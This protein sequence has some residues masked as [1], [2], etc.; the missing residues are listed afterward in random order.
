MLQSPTAEEVHAATALINEVFHDFCFDSPASR[1]NAFGLLLTAVLRSLIC[2]CVPAAMINGN[3]PGVG[4]G[5]LVD[6]ISLIVMGTEAPKGSAP[7]NDDEMRK[8][9]T[10]L[11]LAGT[12]FVVLDNLKKLLDHA[13]LDAFL[14]SSIWRDRR[15]HTNDTIELPNRSVMIL[16]G[17]NVKV[18]TDMARR[19]YLIQLRTRIARPWEKNSWLHSDL[20][21]WVRSE[22]GKLIGALLTICAGWNAAG[23][24]RST[25]VRMGSFEDW[26]SVIAGILEF[27]GIEGFLANRRDLQ[28]S[29][30]DAENE[31]EDFLT[32]IAEEMGVGKPFTMHELV[33]RMG[34][35]S[36]E[37]NGLKE[38]LPMQFK[39]LIRDGKDANKLNAVLG[40]AFSNRKGSPFGEDGIYIECADKKAS[41]SRCKWIIRH[42]DA[43]L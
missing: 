36:P 40:A 38:A 4:K 17:N 33:S 20:K 7:N 35:D 27:L 41:G 8:Q 6:V 12:T 37:M 42:G 39:Q 2:G 34:L 24:P 9:L 22:R 15:L 43:A 5:M 30:A 13:S 23:Q 21:A 32:I 10:T 29:A 11:L 25:S 28:E 31:W 14:T 26:A 1:A 18:G 3:K 19:S 16:T